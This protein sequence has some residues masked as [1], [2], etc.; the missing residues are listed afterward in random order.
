MVEEP[1]SAAEEEMVV[2]VAATAVAVA[3]SSATST[4]SDCSSSSSKLVDMTQLQAGGQEG[5]EVGGRQVE[6]P[7][8]AMNLDPPAN[9][10]QGESGT[11]GGLIFQGTAQQLSTLSCSAFGRGS[12]RREAA[13]IPATGLSRDRRKRCL[14]RMTT[15]LLDTMQLCNPNFQYASQVPRRLLTDPSEGVGND[16]LDNVDGVRRHSLI[17][18]RA[19]FAC[20]LTPAPRP[21]SQN[22][23]CRVNDV[24]KSPTTSYLVLELL[25]QGT[26]GQV[27]RCLDEATKEMVAVKVIKNK[28]AYR[29]QSLVEVQVARMLNEQF[30][31][32]DKKH[33]VRLL[34]TFPALNH[35]CMVF[36][37]LSI[38]LYEVLKQNQFRGLQLPMIRHILKQI[39]D[40]LTV[41]EQANIIHCD[42]KPENI[43]LA[44][45]DGSG[46]NL[47]RIKVI[48]FGSACFEGRTIYTYIQSRFYRSPEVLLGLP[49]DGAIDMWSLGCICLELFLG[50][51]IFPGASDHNQMQRIVDMTGYPPEFMLEHGRFATKFFN[52]IPTGQSSSTPGMRPF[53]WVLKT[54]EEFAADTGTSVPASKTYFK[55]SRIP[56]IVRTYPMPFRRR[57]SPAAAQ[58]EME[59]RRLFTHFCLGLLQPNPWKRWTPRQA[60]T[61]PFVTG[62]PAPANLE[63]FTLSDD[64]ETLDRRYMQQ[65][66]MQEQTRAAAAAAVLSSALPSRLPYSQPVDVPVPLGMSAPVGN[67]FLIGGTPQPTHCYSQAGVMPPQPLAYSFTHRGLHHPVSDFAYA[68]QRP[69]IRYE[70]YQSAA[71]SSPQHVS[72]VSMQNASYVAAP[73]QAMAAAP[74]AV[75]ARSVDQQTGQYFYSPQHRGSYVHPAQMM[76]TATMTMQPL[77]PHFAHPQQQQ[78]QH[79]RAQGRPRSLS[80]PVVPVAG[81]KGQPQGQQGKVGQGKGGKDEEKSRRRRPSLGKRDNS[82]DWDVFQMEGMTSSSTPQESLPLDSGKCSPGHED[83]PAGMRGHKQLG[84]SAIQEENVDNFH[85]RSVNGTSKVERERGDGV[86]PEVI[87]S[88]QADVGDL[89]RRVSFVEQPDS[90]PAMPHQHPSSS[91]LAQQLEQY[92]QTQGG[93]DA[94]RLGPGGPVLE[95]DAGPDLDQEK[96]IGGAGM[97]GSTSSSKWTKP[98]SHRRRRRRSGASSVTGSAAGDGGRGY[99]FVGSPQHPYLGAAG[100]VMPPP[101]RSGTTALAMSVSPGHV[102]FSPGAGGAVPG[103]DLLGVP[104]GQQWRGGW[105]VMPATQPTRLQWGLPPGPG[106]GQGQGTGMGPSQASPRSYH[107]QSSPRAQHMQSSPQHQSQHLQESPRRGSSV[108][109]RNTATDP[110]GTFQANRSYVGNPTNS[111]RRSHQKSKPSYNEYQG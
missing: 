5:A 6:P 13:W 109:P 81:G 102:V 98:N 67:G 63:T 108:A 10:P 19:G 28:P 87:A 91:L 24:L 77:M 111:A 41:L 99:Y 80:H 101:D 53:R 30:D 44:S 82:T 18:L 52:R 22:L 1:A 7:L 94:S 20:V 60:L 2:M 54:P 33:I 21:Q 88:S 45:S 34:D 12:H 4:L 29:N 64:R 51:P 47:S 27:F 84:N 42:L 9:T 46:D 110:P 72:A 73:A 25:G 90:G 59:S 79:H 11:S 92:Q 78:S 74:P 40:A 100:Y 26:F 71:E 50:L 8:E 86:Q 14:N 75:W 3:D 62:Q 31:P 43:L 23:I 58:Q 57:S 97:A 55:H 61:H 48:D 17:F 35:L 107:M 49:Y 68:L 32:A 56:D 66:I 106:L 15:G 37:M 95:A 65:Q 70:A 103:A 76:A 93:A 69:G 96:G 85:K 89:F 39:I 36:E 105:G 104:G 38:N 83:S 16:G